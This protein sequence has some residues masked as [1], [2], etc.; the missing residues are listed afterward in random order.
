MAGLADVH[1]E[2]PAGI[3]GIPGAACTRI[4]IRHDDLEFWWNR[5]A[6]PGLPGWEVAMKRYRFRSAITGRFVT[7]AY[8]KRYPRR[9]VRERVASPAA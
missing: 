6:C 9:T 1:P 4:A 3:T 2:H 5:H 8:A 7:A